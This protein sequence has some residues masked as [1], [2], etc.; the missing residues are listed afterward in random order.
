M[1]KSGLVVITGDKEID[2]RLKSLLPR[3]QKKVLRSAM[4]KGM[5]LVLADAQARVPVLTGLTKE[6]LKLKAMKRSRSRVGLNVQVGNAEGLT[7]TRPRGRRCSTPPW[8]SGPRVK[9]SCA[10]LTTARGQRP[11]TGPCKRC[12]T[13]PS[14]RR[15][16]ARA[17]RVLRTH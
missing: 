1:A 13:E 16:S 4:R 5:K 17:L 9:P 8:S 3:I 2:R 14:A 12:S 11:A 15:R 7:K 10:R 6:H